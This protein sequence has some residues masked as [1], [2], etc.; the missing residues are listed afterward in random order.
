MLATLE[1]VL[2]FSVIGCTLLRLFREIP[3]RG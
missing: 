3:E 1:T 2:A